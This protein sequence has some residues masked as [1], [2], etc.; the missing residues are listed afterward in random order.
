M[1]NIDDFGFSLTSRNSINKISLIKKDF[2][3]IIKSGVFDAVPYVGNIISTYR[4]V[5]NIRDKIFIKKFLFFLQ[6][7]ESKTIDENK[8]E[9][10]KSKIINDKDYRIKVTESLI[11]YVDD[12]KDYKKI[13]IFSNLFIGYIYGNY[14]WEYF[15]RLTDALEKVDISNLNLIPK[16]DTTQGKE[17][18]KYDENKITVEANLS[19]AGIVSRLSVWSSDL[20]PT[21][22]GKDL[23][24]YGIEKLSQD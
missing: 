16:I 9:E 20:Y 24:K 1:E 11:N 22:I 18:T 8:F 5:M 14:N 12:F 13:E 19:S 7:Y 2:I 23:Y 10:F 21:K 15:L 6:S 3:E 17:I 4:G